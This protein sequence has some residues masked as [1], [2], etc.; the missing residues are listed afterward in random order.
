MSRRK[1]RRRPAPPRRRGPQRALRSPAAV[2]YPPGCG[3]TDKSRKY[4]RSYGRGRQPVM[5][6][7][8]PADRGRADLS[9]PVRRRDEVASKGGVGEDREQAGGP[10]RSG[11]TPRESH[12]G[13]HAPVPR[14]GYEQRAPGVAD[15][16]QQPGEVRGKGRV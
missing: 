15:E 9:T 1:P 2:P 7:E 13:V 10:D 6:E 16:S 4:Q 5:R 14:R 11:L 12:R 8:N 3:G